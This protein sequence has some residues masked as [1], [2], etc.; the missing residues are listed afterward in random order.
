M[1]GGLHR[2][3]SHAS[4]RTNVSLVEHVVSPAARKFAFHARKLPWTLGLRT[5]FHTRVGKLSVPK[6]VVSPAIFYH[7]VTGDYEAPELTLLDEYLSP[8]DRVIELGAGIGFLANR[9]GRRCPHQPHVTVEAS[10]RMADL[11]RLNT[12]HL[13][14]IEVINAVAARRPADPSRVNG[15]R[16][17]VDF[18]EYT[19]YWASST[20]PVHLT[21]PHRR[22]VRTLQ[23][24]IVDLDDLIRTRRATMLVCDIE[25]G[26]YEL[27]KTFDLD[28]PKILMELHW[29]DLGMTRAMTV[30]RTLQERGYEL[31]GSPDV[32]MAIRSTASSRPSLHTTASSARTKSASSL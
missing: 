20:F 14:N 6:A 16:R 17:T 2:D 18:H 30:L 28:V 24:N 13:G 8:D 19:D 32:L 4:G 23:V 27:V 5:R 11:I 12:S 25:G 22:L 29:R 10:P 15:S 9:Y 3:Q 1:Q 31:L 7:L 26:E 21:N